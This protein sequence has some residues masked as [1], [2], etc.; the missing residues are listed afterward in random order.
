VLLL[1]QAIATQDV[2][3]PTEIIELTPLVLSEPIIASELHRLVDDANEVLDC[4]S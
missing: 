2:E 4:S 1:P 3:A